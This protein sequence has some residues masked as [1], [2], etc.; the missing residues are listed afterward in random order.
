MAR[1]E[2]TMMGPLRGQVGGAPHARSIA[3]LLRSAFGRMP[4]EREVALDTSR[5]WSSQV[6]R[7]AMVA[8]VAGEVMVTFE[9]D[10]EDHVLGPG[11]AFQAPGRGRVAAAAFRP[12]VIRLAA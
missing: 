12:S 5:A 2:L 1:N 3:L 8:V 7:G 9:G 4:A 6:S 10:L 11:E